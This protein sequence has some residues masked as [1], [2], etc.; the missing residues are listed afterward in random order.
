MF[1]KSSSSVIPIFDLLGFRPACCN[2][3]GHD[4][5]LRRI[6]LGFA[7]PISAYCAIVTVS[8]QMVWAHR[9]MSSKSS[10][11][12]TPLAVSSNSNF[13]MPPD[14]VG[15]RLGGVPKVMEPRY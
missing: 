15:R 6:V 3:S 5:N 7:F 8:L 2:A 12:A 10:V 9:R 14:R 13:M 11:S 4:P 1:S